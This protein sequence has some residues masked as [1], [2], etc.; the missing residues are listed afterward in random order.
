MYASVDPLNEKSLK[1][2][3][4]LKITF[5]PTT[6][7]F[8]I[9][10]DKV[11]LVLSFLISKPSFVFILFYRVS[12]SDMDFLKWPLGAETLRILIVYLWLHDHESY[13]FVFHHPVFKKVLL[14]GLNS[15]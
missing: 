15:L 12:H 13:P 1:L 14:A 8:S 9:Y 5:L 7:H 6:Y 11:S 3:T 2:Q 10:S 4:N